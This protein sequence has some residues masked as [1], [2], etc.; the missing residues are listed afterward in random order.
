ME[1]WRLA[2]GARGLWRL[3]GDRRSGLRHRG[4][5]FLTCHNTLGGARSIV[6]NPPYGG[7]GSHKAQEKS[8]LAMLEFMRHALALTAFVQGQ[9]A[10]LVRLQWIAGKRAADL[11]S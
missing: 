6:T 5:N 2:C 10:L 9:L 1:T 8:S 7:T 4:I 3:V 11:L